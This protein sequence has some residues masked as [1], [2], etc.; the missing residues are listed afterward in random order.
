MIKKSLI[1]SATLIIPKEVQLMDERIILMD[2]PTTVRGFIF[3]DENGDP[4]IVLN[5]RLSYEQNIRTWLHEK[6]HI[7]RGEMDDPDYHEYKEE[8]I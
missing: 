2:L 3:Y 7:Q 4:V 8:D 5:A 6:R 1:Q